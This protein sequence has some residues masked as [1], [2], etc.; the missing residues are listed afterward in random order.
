MGAKTNKRKNLTTARM[1]NMAEQAR[2]ERDRIENE[3]R[4]WIRDKAAMRVIAVARTVV[5]GALQ[6][7]LSVYDAID[8]DEIPF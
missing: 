3:T 2:F 8:D 4:R 7:A 6:A 1:H 5:D